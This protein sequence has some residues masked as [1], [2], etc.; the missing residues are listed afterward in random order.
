[1]EK[2]KRTNK[3]HLKTY[4]HSFSTHVS[5]VWNPI[6]IC[7]QS[8]T[9]SACKQMNKTN[10]IYFTVET[11]TSSRFSG[12][13]FSYFLTLKRTFNKS[14]SA[15]GGSFCTGTAP[16]WG[17]DRDKSY[18]L[19][20]SVSHRTSSPL[21]DFGAHTCRACST[22]EPFNTQNANCDRPEETEHDLF[23]LMTAPRIQTGR[24]G[25]KI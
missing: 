20:P 23:L 25:G 11:Q 15:D 12:G 1:M 16:R 18:F 14:H 13:S 8:Q 2:Q 3:W 24:M 4:F 9:K 19:F 10:L 17:L 21:V 5:R 6:F 22:E 7:T